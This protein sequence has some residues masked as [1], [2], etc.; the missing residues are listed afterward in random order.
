MVQV[1][2]FFLGEEQK[3]DICLVAG[4]PG[5]KKDSEEGRKEAHL[6]DGSS[7]FLDLLCA[8]SQVIRGKN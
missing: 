4:S 2:V 3:K 1:L 5:V 7:R 8:L 6:D